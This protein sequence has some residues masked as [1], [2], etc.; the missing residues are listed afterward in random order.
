MKQGQ[1]SKMLQFDKNALANEILTRLE[2]ELEDALTAW[3]N[4]VIKYMGFNEFKRSANTDYE[5]KKEGQKII[6]YLKANT[7]VLADSYGTG[8]LM[9][10]DNPG[11]QEYKNS[12]RWNPARKSNAIAGRPEGAYTDVLSG[13]Q[14][15]S[16]GY[17]EGHN[18]EG[19]EMITGYKINPVAPSRAVEIALGWLY[20]TYLPRAYS[21][22]IHKVDF[23][24]YLIE[25]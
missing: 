7:Y 5:I 16:S 1:V 4:E 6:A 22:V 15:W 21:S 14:K 19:G 13:K 11:Y 18:I 9:L 17:M 3:K 12:T 2:I 10:L 20:R 25:Y 24:K 8:S 23:S